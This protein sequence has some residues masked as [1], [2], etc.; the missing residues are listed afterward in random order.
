[1][2]I[3]PGIFAQANKPS[4][5]LADPQ[6]QLMQAAAAQNA[7]NQNR[8][9]QAQ[10]ARG[11]LAQ[12]AIDPGTGQYSPTAFNRLL[13][14]TPAAALVAPEAVQQSQGLMANQNDLATR[15]AD[16]MR[17]VLPAALAAPD[18]QIHQVTG[19][20]YMEAMKQGLIKP[21]DALRQALALPNDPAALRQQLT[22][23]QQGLMGPDGQQANTYGVPMTQSD[24]QN[25]YSGPL[26][27]A[28]LGAGYKPNTA[29][30][31]FPSRG[32]LAGRTQVGVNP[33]G[34]P[35][36]GPL[37]NVTPSNLAGPAGQPS[38]LG[39]GR[40]P[41]ALQN[42]NRPALSPAPAMPA[43]PVPNNGEVTTGLGPAQTAAQSTAG[44]TSAAAFKDIADQGVAAQSRGAVL[45]NMLSDTK[46]F[47]PGPGND[48]ILKLRQI[49]GRLGINGNVDATTAAESFN[50]LAAQLANQ[51]GSGTDARL[52]I[53]Q[54]GNPHADLS[55]GGL[56]QMLRQLRGNEDYL[57]ARAKLA[58]AYPNPADRSGFES[59]QASQLDPRTFQYDR[60]TPAQKATYFK[61]IDDK[62]A[63]VR[64]HD[65]AGKLLNRGG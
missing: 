62:A 33:D 29:M 2:A 55:P 31:V 21:E 9:F 28:R 46:L 39:T 53:S 22:M 56:D 8:L 24:G 59:T 5:P 57:G 35:R 14:Q 19:D 11:E 61:S 58:A 43:P 37:A 45:D 38:P 50:K 54:A 34:S 41:P 65:A 30:P 7:V 47:T 63:F 3:D 20:A 6:Q 40:L 27:P 23:A 16:Y 36:T 60:L 10:Q 32:E 51:Q 12:Q 42:P 48:Q 52:S 44:T 26:M 1:M 25:N 4:V 17:R 15:Q 64:A 13:G 18:A 49:A